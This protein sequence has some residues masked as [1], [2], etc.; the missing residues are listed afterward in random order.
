MTLSKVLL[1]E[2]SIQRCEFLNG[3]AEY[4]L[5]DPVIQKCTALFYPKIW[6]VYD[7]SRKMIVNSGYFRGPAPAVINAQLSLGEDWPEKADVAPEGDYYYI[8]PVHAHYGHFLLAT[9]S[10][11]WALRHFKSK[12]FRLVTYALPD[13]DKHP[14]INTLLEAAGY[15]T[16]DCI[17]FPRPTWIKDLIIPGPSFEETNFVHA[18][19]SKLCVETGINL[20][21]SILPT[22][23]STPAYIAKFA[24][25]GGVALLENE[26]V[27]ANIMTH[28]GVDVVFPEQM[29]L[30]QQIR[31]FSERDCIAGLTGSA[32]HTASF[33]RKRRMLILA[34][35]SQVLSNQLLV[36]KAGDHQTDYLY[37]R[38]GVTEH[39]TNEFATVYHMERPEQVA[40][41][42]LRAMDVAASRSSSTPLKLGYDEAL[43]P[44]LPDTVNVALGKP[45]SASSTSP[46]SFRMTNAETAGKAVSGLCT[47]GFAFHTSFDA[48]PWWKVDLEKVTDIQEIR[49]FNRSD[50]LQERASH[51]IVSA[52]NDD[53]LYHEIY[54]REDD[55][56][57]GGLEGGPLQILP[58]IPIAARFVKISLLKRNHMHFDQV[59]IYAASTPVK[60]P[61]ALV[62]SFEPVKPAI[63]RDAPLHKKLQVWFRGG[64]V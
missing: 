20:T 55:E 19:Y 31:L 60:R 49:I 16:A 61:V 56:P 34:Y 9:F 6:A 39:K 35:R 21:A 3:N 64:T 24:L 1:R 30:G 41:D 43:T 5:D 45:A 22:G 48:D 15:S 13:L 47:G 11:L 33:T 63:G 10:R 12:K 62:P 50:R 28:H 52:S 51:L 29:T 42:L 38:F 46:H 4:F 14:Y 7:K 44:S 36:D 53:V 40:E 59:A 2:S 18:A 57:F 37:P 58:E 17:T 32:F 27:I 23:R 25:N 26:E 8:G 54:R